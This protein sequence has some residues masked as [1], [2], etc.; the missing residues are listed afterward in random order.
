MLLFK[1]STIIGGMIANKATIAAESAIRIER[2]RIDGR[3]MLRHAISRLQVDDDFE[4]NVLFPLAFR[5]NIS[6]FRI[7]CAA[8]LKLS[9]S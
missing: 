1:M 3:Q 9:F 4:H 2:T 7:N 6:E 8:Y 5:R